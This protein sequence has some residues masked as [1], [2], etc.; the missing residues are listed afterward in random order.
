[1]VL[2]QLPKNNY[3]PRII[4]LSHTNTRH[5]KKGAS[6]GWGAIAPSRRCNPKNLPSSTRKT[7]N[8]YNYK[9][10]IIKL[11]HTNTRHKKKGASTGWGVV[12]PT[13]L[14]IWPLSAF[15]GS[16]PFPCIFKKK[17][18]QKT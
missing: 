10:R 2:K 6:T 7:E 15:N 1:M 18:N 9:P 5:K 3:K 11:S 8:N 14:K 4:K 16:N 13:R 17:T 12:K